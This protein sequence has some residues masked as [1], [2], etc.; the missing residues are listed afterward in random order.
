ME[1]NNFEITSEWLVCKTSTQKLFDFLS[2]IKNLE[3]ILPKDK[4]HNI[5]LE[6]NELSFQIENII[7]LSLHIRHIQ[8]FNSSDTASIEYLSKPFGNYHLQLNALFQNNQSQIIL[9]G[10]LNPF[11]LSIAKKKLTHLVNRI[12]QELA[13]F[14]IP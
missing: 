14:S 8:P 4:I 2:D 9:S 5:Q 6:N 11:V 3:S 13:S 7:T 10:H 1:N 12:N